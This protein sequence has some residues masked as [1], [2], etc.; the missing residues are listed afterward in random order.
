[1]EIYKL[2]SYKVTTCIES[3]CHGYVKIPSIFY[4]ERLIESAREY[5][6]PDFKAPPKNLIILVSALTGT[7]ISNSLSR[8][9]GR[10]LG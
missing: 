9:S 6:F 7:Y 4:W 2:M 1:M 8:Y 5:I 10:G 3:I